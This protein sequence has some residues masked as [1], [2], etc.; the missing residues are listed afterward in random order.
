MIGLI[1]KFSTISI[2]LQRRSNDIFQLVREMSARSSNEH[3]KP[4]TSSIKSPYE[5][6]I[7][8]SSRRTSSVSDDDDQ[9]VTNLGKAMEAWRDDE[10][11]V[12]TVKCEDAVK[13]D[14][15]DSIFR[16]DFQTSSIVN[17]TQHNMSGK[18][19]GD[20]KATSRLSL[21]S[22][23]IWFDDFAYRMRYDYIFQYIRIH[24]P[25]IV[26][27]QE[28]TP[29]FIKQLKV[30][31]PDIL[32]DYCFSESNLDSATTVIPYGVA[33]LCRRELSPTFSFEYLPTR[34][35][36]KLLVTEFM[37]ENVPFR[38]GTVHLESLDSQQTREEQLKVCAKRFQDLEGNHVSIICG[39]FNFC[40]Y[41]NFY[42]P[43]SQE[44]LRE[45]R[46]DNVCLSETLPDFLDLWPT[47]KDVTVDKGLTFDTRRNEMLSGLG[48]THEQMR[49]DRIIFRPAMRKGAVDNASVDGENRSS[50]QPY[51]IEMVGV[52]A[53]TASG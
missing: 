17:T 22:W 43:S 44:S 32:T 42:M 45:L 8:C 20:R 26:C 21:I 33:T 11:V 34:M 2:N 52:E 24:K 41:R 10:N 12:A 19:Y 5:N 38:I 48:H 40:S 53:I 35:S 29:R 9:T 6:S 49:Y 15:T 27:L 18:F 28:V 37:K 16:P 14:N 46:L 4:S 13:A 3:M 47:L 31:Y 39:D 36:R 23:N 7:F 50:W 1:S 30:D 51:S 25:D